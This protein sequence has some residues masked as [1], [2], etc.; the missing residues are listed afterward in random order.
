MAAMVICPE[1]RGEKSDLTISCSAERCETWMLVCSFCQGLGQVSEHANSLWQKGC[2]LRAARK[3]QGMTQREQVLILEISPLDLN[4]LECGRR[5][6][7]D[8][9]RVRHPKE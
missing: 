1:C 8:V 7:K 4:D 2:E 3:T 9:P 6:L 5:A